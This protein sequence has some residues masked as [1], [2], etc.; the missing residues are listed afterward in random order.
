MGPKR[1]WKD[2]RA[3]V[4]DEGRN[5][6][7]AADDNGIIGE[8]NSAPRRS[9]DRGHDN[10]TLEVS[11]P[12]EFSRDFIARV[13]GKIDKSGECWEWTAYRMPTTGYGQVRTPRGTAYAHRVVY[14]IY[15][16]EIPEGLHIDH[17]CR[18]RGC[19]N[20]DHLEAVSCL[21]NI[22]RGA[23]VALKTHCAK[24]HPWTE[25]NKMVNGSS[26]GR[27]VHCCR[28]CHNR[29]ERERQRRLAA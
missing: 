2:A 10:E 1:D 13:E 17:L 18:N 29:R 4:E 28:P 21:E 14:E 15:K 19:V 12:L 24:G 8:T 9:N 5:A 27:P 3:K 16:G 23:A 11:M 7:S 25:E 6:L 20:P 22:R 26:N